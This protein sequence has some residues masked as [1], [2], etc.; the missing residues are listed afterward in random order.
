[1]VRKAN[2]WT[3][4]IAMHALVVLVLVTLVVFSRSADPTTIVRISP[5]QERASIPDW[6]PDRQ[7]E[8]HPEFVPEKFQE[9]PEIVNVA[10]RVVVNSMPTN[11]DFDQTSGDFGASDKPLQGPQFS[12]A[13][14]TS[15]TSCAFTWGT[16]PP[17]VLFGERT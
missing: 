13:I 17:K 14:G 6:E 7:A 8:K 12:E 11:E 16:S 1:M 3:F 9:D 4:S 2:W 5:Q 10:D 15:T